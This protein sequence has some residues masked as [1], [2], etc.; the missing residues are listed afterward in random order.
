MLQHYRAFLGKKQLKSVD[1]GE[2]CDKIIPVN[3][4]TELRNAGG[5]QR[6]GTVRALG[7]A[8]FRAAP[9][10]SAASRTPHPRYRMTEMP[11]SRGNQGGTVDHSAPDRYGRG[12]FFLE[13]SEE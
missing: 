7:A 9:E 1:K 3:V 10:R 6:E 5:Q 8:A 12:G 2:K 13:R 4:L 11:R